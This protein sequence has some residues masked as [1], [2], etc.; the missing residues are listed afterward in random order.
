VTEGV[1]N[2][3]VRRKNGQD[4]EDE[5]RRHVCKRESKVNM[6]EERDCGRLWH[7]VPHIQ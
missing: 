7:Q 6:K 3:S 2:I 1:K 4:G 5:S